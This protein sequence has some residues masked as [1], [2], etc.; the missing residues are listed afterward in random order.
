MPD[1]NALIR[2]ARAEDVEAL[3]ELHC[4]CFGPED[5]VPVMLGRHY[6]R[7][8]YQWLV[9]SGMS[10]VL[11]MDDGG[12]IVGLVGMA[13]RSFS[14]PMFKACIGEFIWSVLRHPRLLLERRLWRRLVRRESAGERGE[15][16]ASYPGMAQ[17]TIGAVAAD[18]RGR[19]VFP[20]LVDA[21]RAYSKERGSRGIRA[22][23]YKSNMPSRRV[24]IK[25]GW[26]EMPELETTDTVFYVSF[27]DP[28]FA[29][30]LGIQ[31]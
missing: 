19:A 6:V 31:L 20:A 15:R 4:A 16:I 5:H 8:N 13:D 2:L 22:G 18:Y 29:Q 25:S 17:M 27:L 11:V 23:I 1:A 9:T 12:R 28:A 30:E 21:T 3:T 7:A 26:L 14:G 24:F 10:Y